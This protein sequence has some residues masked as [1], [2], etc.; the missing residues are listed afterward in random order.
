M[1]IAARR[2]GLVFMLLAGAL[3]P[4]GADEEA[5]AVDGHGRIDGHYCAAAARLLLDDGRFFEVVAAGMPDGASVDVRGADVG[6]T[7]CGQALLLGGAIVAVPVR[8]AIELT[9]PAGAWSRH[10]VEVDALMRRFPGARLVLRLVAANDDATWAAALRIGQQLLQHPELMAR[11]TL[12]PM[13]PAAAAS[14]GW[15]VIFGTSRD[16]RSVDAASADD[17]ARVLAAPR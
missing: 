11:T 5:T 10:A 1:S 8:P 17:V 4:A 6:P 14:S 9:L 3:L 13:L 7:L 2:Q 15:R 16:A 12:E